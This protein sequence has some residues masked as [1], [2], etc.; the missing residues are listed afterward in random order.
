VDCDDVTFFLAAGPDAS[1]LSGPENAKLQVHLDTC[2]TCRV[3]AA[4]A[5]QLHWV[6]GVPADALADRDLLALAV[7]DPVLFEAEA[8]LARGG[9]GR[10]TRARDRRLG[11]DV[12]IKEVLGRHLN[13]RFEREVSIT[14]RLQHP[15]IVPIYEAGRWPDGSAFYAMRLVS[16]GTLAHA[17]ANTRTLEDR[18]ALLP[19]V[20]AVT[21]ALAYAH[22]QRIVHRD[23]KP[24]N[25]LVGEFGETLVIDWGLAKELD[26]AI[27]DG[28]VRASISNITDLTVAG[29]VMGTPGF[30]SPEQAAGT[31][32]DERT[33]VYALGTILYTLLA[34]T[35]PYWEGDTTLSP[36]RLAARQKAGPP[37]PLATLAPR[38]PKDLQVI[39]ERAM[40][41][42][43]E[44]R[45][46]TAKEMAEELHRFAA[47]Q[48]LRSREYTTRELVVRWLR[49][50][51]TAVIVGAIALVA[52]AIFGMVSVHQTVRRR[53]DAELALARS[54]VEQGRQ[55]LVAGHAGQAAAMLAAAIE[56]VPDDAIARRL[57]ATAV[58]DAERRLASFTGATAAFR[59]DGGVLA[60]GHADGSIALVD[61]ETGAMRDTLAS[62][63]VGM[64][65]IA[66]AGKQLLCTSPKGVYLVDP[67]TRVV[68]AVARGDVQA[69]A[70]VGDR[71]AIADPTGV[72]LVERDGT[73][74][75][76][77]AAAADVR[78]FDVDPR[79]QRLLGRT[80]SATI[81]WTLPELA[82]AVSLPPAVY[83]KLDRDGSVVLA[84]AAALRRYPVAGSSIVLR[85]GES[86][87]LVR[88][89]DGSLATGQELIDG[90]PHPLAPEVASQGVASLDAAHLVTGGFDRVLRI[91]KL[92]LPRALVALD[93]ADAIEELVTN[94]TGTRAV[95]VERNGVIELWDSGHLRDPVVVA[96]VEEPIERLVT[97]RD[98]IA[99]WLHGATG[100]H[101]AMFDAARAR[102]GLVEGWPVGYRP[103][104]TELAVNNGGRLFIYRDGAELHVVTDTSAIQAAAFSSSGAVLATSA[105]NHVTLRDPLTWKII[106]D[107][108]THRDDVTAIALDDGGHLVTGHGDGSLQ[109]WD[110][111]TGTAGAMLAGHSAHID[112]VAIR[113]DRL[114][115]RS[116]DGSTRAWDLP[117][118]APRGVVL[119][120]VGQGVALAPSGR[121]L[122][123]VDRSALVSV[124]DA[125]AGRL[126]AQ[127]PAST[128]LDSIAFTD[129]DHVV[130]G[131]AAGTME[132]IDLGERERTTADIVRL[133][134]TMGW[135]LFDERI[136]DRRR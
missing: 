39:V 19:H 1:T 14:A 130:V 16:G 119:P 13:A 40:A 101:V 33:D 136:V 37:T 44:A 129:E 126:L 41:R 94:A 135:H 22:A 120:S 114:M 79:G 123:T 66:Y 26:R 89:R 106:G 98:R 105:T 76:R 87:P 4:P 60:I 69:A 5:E 103:G 45:Y 125:D 86:Q 24:G 18:L 92:E 96:T 116:W 54:R 36:A 117:T 88:L 31:D 91:V 111:R 95:T 118:G 59:P 77:D 127:I 34:G 9:M 80:P 102:V 56:R 68:A 7:V 113:G 57:A 2:E 52:I 107:V 11:R 27:G 61:P 48:L 51:R 109:L 35:A 83:A 50:H 53:E 124:W 133:A 71:V 128:A 21:D 75:R 58:R 55:L 100:S 97:G 62:A 121:Y 72:R 20:I 42:D 23:L 131:G 70:L 10:I 108:V 15:A 82:R 112:D 65:A 32:V 43:R 25:V 30:M 49:R 3:L 29:S 115:T 67:D 99:A 38:V 47:G 74:A 81:V 90:T 93:T 46:A 6:V 132:L 78:D 28:P 84:D 110:T 134:T 12:A 122:A 104:G 85:A 64:T 63:A 8:E 73:V 17:I